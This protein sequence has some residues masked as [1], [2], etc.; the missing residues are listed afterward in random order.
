MSSDRDSSEERES[1]PVDRTNEELAPLPEYKVAKTSSIDFA[2][3]LTTP[4]KL[5]EDLKSGCG[6]QLW[7][8]GM[9]LAKHMLR[10]HRE[11]MQ[12]SRILEIG[13]GG[14]LVGLGCA[15]GSDLEIPMFLTDQEEMFSLM[16]YNIALNGLEEKVL[17][18]I[19]NWGEPLTQ[20]IIDFKPDIVLAADCVYFEPAF[21]L[22]MQTLK[23][24]LALSPSTT[25]YFCFMKRRRA[26]MYFLKTARKAFTVTEVVDEDRPVF[27]RQG[28]FL[29]TFTKK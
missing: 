4:L 3:L 11:R 29:Y 27:S 25:V 12:Q 10:C 2:G 15:L 17:P 26:D 20:E 18:R 5:H 13:A 24:L 16:K 28:L 9:V 23:D 7:P 1:F 14:G 19:L 6:G 22:L 21:P 8:A